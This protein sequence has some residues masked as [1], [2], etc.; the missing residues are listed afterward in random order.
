ME[1]DFQVIKRYIEGKERNGD[2]DRII[3]WFSDI[4]FESDI[5]KKYK[6]LWDEM[7]EDNGLEECDG[8]KIL[9]RIYHKMKN[10]EYQ[11]R[12]PKKGMI[13]FLNVLTK[14]AAI[15]F[16]PLLAY[17][18]V[19]KGSDISTHS[20]ASYSQIYSPLGTRTMF[21]LPDGS[22]GWLNGGSYLKFPTEFKGKSRDVFLEGE[23]YFDVLSDSK[24]PFSVNGKNRSVIAYGT[25][26]NVCAYPDDPEIQITLIKGSIG[27]FERNNGKLK[28]LADLKPG[29]MYICYPG[30]GLYRIE[31][32]D[33]NK[34]AAW[35]NGMLAFRDEPF[36]EVVRKMNR[37]YNVEIEIMDEALSLHPYQATFMDETLDEVLNL[38]KISAPMEFKDLGRDNNA[39][40][41]FGKRKI[42]LYY[43]HN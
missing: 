42:E 30:T 15:L 21:F 18:W 36:T 41:T 23:A 2:K 35:K 12:P 3:D 40:G 8:S 34:V 20:Q 19:V 4:R 5:R 9:G 33:T 6:L 22:T 43:K 38:L 16:I 28:N 14:V 29:Q 26:F 17:L 31:N 11:S 27:I 39:D 1:V 32:V 10:D 24:K 25:S 37:W 7:T 13:R